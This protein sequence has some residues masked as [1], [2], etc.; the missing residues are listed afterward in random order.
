MC[1]RW[2]YWYTWVLPV[3]LDHRWRKLLFKMPFTPDGGS[4][5]ATRLHCTGEAA[6]LLHGDE[7]H[8]GRLHLRHHPAYPAGLQRVRDA[9]PLPRILAQGLGCLIHQGAPLSVTPAAHS[10]FP[11]PHANTLCTVVEQDWNQQTAGSP[12]MPHLHEQW[13]AG[14]PGHHPTELI[15]HLLLSRRS[16]SGRGTA[17]S[18]CSSR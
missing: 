15:G 7:A 11:V 6:G 8:G 9:Q 10:W 14:P 1:T 17:S 18:S 4:E 3:T 13:E 2:L 12:S 16:A 5:G